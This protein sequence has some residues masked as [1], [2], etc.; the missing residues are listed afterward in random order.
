MWTLLWKTSKKAHRSRVSLADIE[1]TDNCESYHNRFPWSGT[2]IT[3]SIGYMSNFCFLFI[4][5]A[6]YTIFLSLITVSKAFRRHHGRTGMFDNH[7]I[8]SA[9][10]V[11]FS[12]EYIITGG[13]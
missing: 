11:P 13:P 8:L 4:S 1:S 5:T 7:L 9:W 10:L 3:I 2:L 12:F 6:G